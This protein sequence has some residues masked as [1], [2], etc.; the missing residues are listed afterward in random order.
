VGSW[1]RGEFFYAEIAIFAE[2]NFVQQI[3]SCQD[4]YVLA[5]TGL[6]FQP[7]KVQ[8]VGCAPKNFRAFSRLFNRHFSPPA[9]RVDFARN[10]GALC[11]VR[12][13][14]CRVEALDSK[15]ITNWRSVVSLSNAITLRS[16]SSSES[17]WL[18][19]RSGITLSPVRD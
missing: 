7:N 3:A 4:I 15:S 12:E 8:A 16:N 5:C 6:G 19:L 10:G 17:I 11:I 2:A 1:L 14:M 18:I 13:R 9:S